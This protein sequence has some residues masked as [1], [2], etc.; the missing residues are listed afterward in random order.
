MFGIST[1][2]TTGEAFQEIWEGRGHVIYIATGLRCLNYHCIANIHFEI[3]IKEIVSLSFCNTDIPLLIYYVNQWHQNYGLEPSPRPC[4]NQIWKTPSTLQLHLKV[5]QQSS[6][7]GF[8]KHVKD[9]QKPSPDAACYSFS[10][11]TLSEPFETLIEME[12]WFSNTCYKCF[13]RSITIHYK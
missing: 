7:R 3:N 8:F 4:K 1:I 13:H 6:S 9:Q 10:L 2:I 5:L 11:M 12:G